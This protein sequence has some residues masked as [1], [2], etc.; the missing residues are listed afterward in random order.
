MDL[1][2][3]GRKLVEIGKKEISRTGGEMFFD[4]PDRW[5]EE[6]PKWR[7]INGHVSKTYLKSEAKGGA[8]CLA[9]GCGE[10]V[11]LTFPEDKDGPLKNDIGSLL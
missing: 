4:K 6:G 2:D 5:W 7:C 1:I 10:Y 11:L 9:G 3:L 8:C